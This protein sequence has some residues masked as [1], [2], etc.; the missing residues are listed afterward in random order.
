M[1]ATTT[2]ASYMHVLMY[3]IMCGHTYM[4]IL[5]TITLLMILPYIL[6][7]KQLHT[8]ESVNQGWVIDFFEVN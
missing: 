2:V 8:S 3:S 6:M 7:M 1:H 4:D 5:Q